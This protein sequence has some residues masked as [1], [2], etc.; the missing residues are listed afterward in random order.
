MKA[1]Q[2][3]STKAKNEKVQKATIQIQNIYKEKFKEN[4]INSFML[5]FHSAFNLIGEL[6]LDN[7]NEADSKEEREVIVAE[8]LERLE[9]EYRS[10]K[11]NIQK[12]K[13]DLERQQNRKAEKEKRQKA[14]KSIKK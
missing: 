5:G 6:Y 10:A 3:E 14:K 13:E 2:S 11:S 9:F 12:G 1:R 4:A 8:M 7:I